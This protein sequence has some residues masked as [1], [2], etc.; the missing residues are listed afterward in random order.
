MN[1]EQLRQ[2]LEMLLSWLR[3]FSAAIIAQLMAGVDEWSILLNAGLAA[4]LPVILRWL[5]V[6]DPSYG[7]GSK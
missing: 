1:K 7:R 5:D 3:V 4:V 6:D 2:A